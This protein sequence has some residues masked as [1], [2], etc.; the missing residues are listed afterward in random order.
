MINIFCLFRMTFITRNFYT[1]TTPPLFPTTLGFILGILCQSLTHT[2]YNPFLFLSSIITI[3]LVMIRAIKIIPFNPPNLFIMLFLAFIAGAILY[4]N[5][6]NKHEQFYYQTQ[7]Q[8]FDIIGTVTDIATNN[9]ATMKTSITLQTNN[10]KKTSSKVWQPL[11]KKILIYTAY[12]HKICVGDVITL[13]KIQF[14][15]PQN[16]SFNHYLVK[17]E[18]AA[19][20]FIYR[21]IYTLEY[22]PSWSLNRWIF[23]QKERLFNNIQKKMSSKTF[24]FFSSLFLGN[25]TTLKTKIQSMNEQFKKWGISH[26]LARSGIHLTIF[27]FTW[28]T[29]LCFLPLSFI[30]KQYILII[31]SIIYFIF[32]WPS[33]SF[34]R[35]FSIFALYQLCNLSK[36]PA[37][38]L[39]LLFLTCFLFLI[40]NPMQLFFLDFQLSFSLTF[41]LAWFN[42]LYQTKQA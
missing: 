15:K 1:F 28:Q 24:T 19:S 35:A 10:I 22:R 7:N 16:S 5:Q 33:V 41:A 4:Q 30:I 36:R 3:F 27:I 39:H 14:K 20:L 32:S 38:F 34:A 42:Q 37:H 29:L 12:R 21:L 2:L 9:H 40:L 8:H 18:I 23:N 6:L 13:L 25:R 17:K 26:L 11:D 31:F